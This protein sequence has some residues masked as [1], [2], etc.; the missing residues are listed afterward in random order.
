M[1]VLQA[2]G[3]PKSDVT[4]IRGLKSRD[5]TIAV[6]GFDIESNEQHCISRVREQLSKAIE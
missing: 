6:T 2:L 4:I 5:K 3:R 1:I